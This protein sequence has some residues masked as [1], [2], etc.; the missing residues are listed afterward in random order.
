LPDRSVGHWWWDQTAWFGLEPLGGL[1]FED[2]AAVSWGPGRIDLFIV[3]TGS[4]IVHK[5]WG[6]TQ[7]LG[8]AS[9][10]AGAW[11]TTPT[12]ASWGP[13]R[14][15]LFAGYPYIYAF[16]Q[17]GHEWFDQTAWFGL[18]DRGCCLVAAP[19][20]VS[21]GIDRIDVFGLESNG[22]LAHFFFGS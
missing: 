3:S 1:S 13:G 19:A 7:W 9:D 21:W 11:A 8:W 4:A 15:D 6:G 20:A 5:W 12:V 2:P 14:L 18:D 22:N 17:V 10:V 16:V